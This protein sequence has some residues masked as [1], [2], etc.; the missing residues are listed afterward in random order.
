[1]LPR[2]P[3]HV[4]P[5]LLFALSVKGAEDIMSNIWYLSPSCQ[6]ANIGV[7]GYG[8]EAEQMYLLMDEITPH[9]DRAG[10]SFHVADR[11]MPIAKRC[12]ESNE[13]GAKFHFALH[14]NAGGKG[15]ARGPVGIYYSDAGKAFCEKLV[16]GL[17]E[18][19]QENNR[20]ENA[21]QMKGLY[22]LRKTKAPAALLEVDFHDSSGGVAFITGRR[23][24]IAEAIAKVIIEA[25][26]KEF[27]PVTAGEYADEAVRLGLFPAGTHWERPM[28]T[29]DAAILAV[30]LIRML[31]RG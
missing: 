14:S 13:M 8:S 6:E 19:G 21:V 31:E 5:G 20:C 27:V 28:T 15:K 1:M 30:K 17:L 23:R 12:R 4:Q 29:E 16:A 18:L 22:E 10:V 7:D 11:E 3:F 26:G 9:L 24:E 2:L 25:D